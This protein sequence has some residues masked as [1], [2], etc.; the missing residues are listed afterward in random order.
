MKKV[1]MVDR[2]LRVDILSLITPGNKSGRWCK[3]KWVSLK[4][5]MISR[6]DI[7]IRK[8]TWWRS[9]AMSFTIS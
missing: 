6:A 8:C 9:V 1:I 3:W 4:S 7:N 5:W 2:S